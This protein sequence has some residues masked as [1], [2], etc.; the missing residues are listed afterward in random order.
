MGMAT[1]DDA[2]LVTRLA[3]LYFLGRID[4]ASNFA[5][6]D[7]FVSSYGGFV[8][9]YPPGTEEFRK[10]VGLCGWFE[11]VGTLYKHGLLNHDLLFDWLA[12][13]QTWDRVKGFALGM[14]K[15][16]KVPRLWENFE[17]MA[18]AQGD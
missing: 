4:E 5:W 14:R 9:K 6:S 3:E 11:T 15:D 16:R 8:K 13:A 2:N 17:L 7:R 1:H 10:L 18:K 12:V